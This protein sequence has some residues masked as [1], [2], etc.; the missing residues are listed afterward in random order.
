ML[1]EF[2]N[3][4][5]EGQGSRGVVSG[6]ARFH[7]VGG[8]RINSPVQQ[9]L[10][11]IASELLKFV[12]GRGAPASFGKAGRTIV[13]RRFRRD[14]DGVPLWI[15]FFRS[16][17]GLFISAGVKKGVGK[18]AFQADVIEL[19]RGKRTIF[20]DCYPELGTGAVGFAFVVVLEEN[21]EVAGNRMIFRIELFGGT[22]RSN[23]A[24]EVGASVQLSS[25]QVR[26]EDLGQRPFCQGRS[27]FESGGGDG[28]GA[29]G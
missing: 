18:I 21:G 11:S 22:E 13:K 2:A 15:Q 20:G 26:F 27:G 16:F 6:R 23:G 19:L 25:Q 8:L 9:K 5:G 14:N 3:G 24:G 17:A 28:L 12:V 10:A 29:S 4:G 7:Q 1:P